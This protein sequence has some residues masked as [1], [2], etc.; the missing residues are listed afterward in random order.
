MNGE[1]ERGP[2]PGNRK[3]VL[4]RGGSDVFAQHVAGVLKDCVIDRCSDDAE[5]LAILTRRPYH[6][7]LTGGETSGRHDV[8]LLRQ[9][10]LVRPHTRF[11]ITTLDSAKED[12]IAAM[13]HHAFSYFSKPYF[14]A[15]FDQMLWHGTTSVGWEHGIEVLSATTSWIKLNACCEIVTADRLVQFINEV[16]DLPGKLREEVGFA[17]REILMNAMEHG[18]NFDPS[19]H[20]EVSYVMGR[21]IVMCRVR[22]PGAGFSLAELDHASVSNPPEDPIRH[23]AVRESQGLRPGG[24]G[25]M[26]SKKLVDEL[27]YGEKGNEVLLIKYLDRNAAADSTK[28]EDLSN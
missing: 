11:I 14:E 8:G 23:L 16:S 18:G 1:H 4:L 10:H 24:F 25:V 22:D 2:V 15:A 21:R 19:E 17:F 12:V 26:L 27:I 6:L 9:I 5:L 28:Q 13:R 20:V 7:V 3:S